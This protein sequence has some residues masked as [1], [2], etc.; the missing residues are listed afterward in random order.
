MDVAGGMADLCKGN[1]SSPTLRSTVPL[2]QV[3]CLPDR[4]LTGVY[5]ALRGQGGRDEFLF[6]LR[7]SVKSPLLRDVTHDTV[8]RFRSCQQTIM[9]A[10]DG[11]PLL[12]CAIT[13]AIAID[14]PSANMWDQDQV[15]VTFEELLDTGDIEEAYEIIDNLSR[16]QH[17]I[18]IAARHSVRARGILQRSTD[19]Q[20]LWLSRENAFP[21]LTFGPEVELQLRR[22]NPGELSTLVNRLAELDDAASRWRDIG[23]SVPPWPCKVTDEH[24]SVKSTPSLREAR[25]FRSADG[26]SALFF[27][28]ARFGRSR[29]IHL[30]FDARTYGIEIGYIGVHLPLN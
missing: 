5:E 13:N 25:R 4:S 11:E 6:L 29:R 15:P 14:F 2:D 10:S 22:L 28:H 17:A 8:N 27:W 26:T 20:R 12:Y 23:G 30:R 18:R 19:Y 21:H 3:Y 1:I 16:R 24:Q 9:S 7:L